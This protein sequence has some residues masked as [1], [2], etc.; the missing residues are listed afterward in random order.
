MAKSA[1][2]ATGSFYKFYAS[3]QAIFLAVY[4]AENERLRSD[5]SKQLRSGVAWLMAPR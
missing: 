2:I 5:L 3:K 4:D 1:G